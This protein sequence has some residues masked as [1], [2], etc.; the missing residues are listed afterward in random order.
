MFLLGRKAKAKSL[1]LPLG[2]IDYPERLAQDVQDN[3]VAKLR[4]GIG[5]EED[6]TRLFNGHLRLAISIAAR[7]ANKVKGKD[8][9]LVNEAL[10]SLWNATGEMQEKLVDNNFTPWCVTRIHSDLSAF[11]SRDHLIRVAQ[12]TYSRHLSEGKEVT[13]PK[14]QSLTY[15]DEEEDFDPEEQ[16]QPKCV[17]KSIC[18]TFEVNNNQEV[19]DIQDMINK[20]VTTENE[21]RVVDYRRRGFNGPEIAQKMNKSSAWVSQIIRKVEARFEE[22]ERSVK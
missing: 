11:L 5:T 4:K 1:A 8:G 13:F 6:R 19:I 17:A 15:Y 22:L 2:N 12:R 20:A 18:T 3:L 9:D 16:V 10:L 7:Y 14:L 21:R